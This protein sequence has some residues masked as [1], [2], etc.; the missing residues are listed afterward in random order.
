MQ[1]SDILISSTPSVDH[2]LHASVYKNNP[3][4]FDVNYRPKL[5]PFIQRALKNGVTEDRII[6][7]AQML[8]SQGLEQNYLFTGKRVHEG[9]KE[10]LFRLYEETYN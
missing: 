3:Y 2:P 4:V 10:E 7:G 9:M 8:I 5:T 1:Q 6:Y